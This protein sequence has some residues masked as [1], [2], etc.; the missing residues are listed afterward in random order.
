MT[1]LERIVARNIRD[2]HVLVCGMSD[3]R[4][5]IRSLREQR[6]VFLLATTI[7]L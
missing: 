6:I 4:R 3:A 1:T 2:R 5:S 7:L